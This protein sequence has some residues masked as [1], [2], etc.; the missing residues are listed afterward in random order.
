MPAQSQPGTTHLIR[1]RTAK[2]ESWLDQHRVGDTQADIVDQLIGFG[3]RDTLEAVYA[4]DLLNSRIA[5]VTPTV[6]H[7]LAAHVEEEGDEVPGGLLAAFEA[8]DV[9]LPQ[10]AEDDGRDPHD[11]H[12]LGAAHFGIHARAA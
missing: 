11:E 3:H 9:P 12:R 1:Y 7:A 2:G 10:I 5:D 4:L 6:L 8:Y